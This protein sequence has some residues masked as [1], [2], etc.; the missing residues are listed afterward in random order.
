MRDHPRGVRAVQSRRH[1]AVRHGVEIG[2]DVPLDPRLERALP[3]R[4]SGTAPRPRRGPKRGD[5]K[6]PPVPLYSVSRK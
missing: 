3:N 4:A 2:Q 6:A 1:Q 5:S